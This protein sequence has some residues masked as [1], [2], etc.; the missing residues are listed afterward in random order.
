MSQRERS[1]LGAFFAH[2]ATLLLIGGAITALLSG[3]LVPY[4]TRAWQNHDKALQ[5]R[6]EIRHEELAVKGDVVKMIG[7]ATADFLA[8][9]QLHPY[10]PDATSGKGLAEYERGYASW[11]RSSSEIAS[12]LAAYFPDSKAETGWRNYSFNMRS[13]Y[14]LLRMAPGD[15]RNFWLRKVSR[16]LEIEPSTIDGVLHSPFGADGRNPTFEAALLELL[17]QLQL[18]EEALVGRVVDSQSALREIVR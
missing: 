18:R 16:Y 6:S 14:L 10:V 8:A 11:S 4:V 9:S 7:R 3:L 13:T 5:R 2:P 17:L 1:E 12:Q 15:A